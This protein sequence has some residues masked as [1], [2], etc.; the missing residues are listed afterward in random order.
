MNFCARRIATRFA[1][2]LSR[3][4]I[5]SFAQLLAALALLCVFS[6][7]GSARPIKYY[8]ISPPPA[9]A[10][11]SG[12]PLNVRILV[13]LPL[14]SH[15]YREDPIVYSSDAHQFGTYETHRW[16]EPPAEMLQSALVRGLRA[17]GRFRA[18]QNQRSDSNGEYLLVSQLYAFNEITGGSWGA[19]LSYDV[20]LREI[21]TG[22]VVW[23]HS[24]NRDEPS[25]GKAVS[26]LVVA[27]DKNVQRSVQEIQA[28]LD[29]Y[30]RNRPAK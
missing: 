3:E 8:Q 19:R 12:E 11:P 15:I 6:G 14:A 9:A 20:D 17:S 22:N 30:F 18:V 28:C 24:Y 27:M 7:C 21:K 10:A 13:R 2:K 23:S 1:V 26:D 29:D 25:G 16:A 5:L 4:R